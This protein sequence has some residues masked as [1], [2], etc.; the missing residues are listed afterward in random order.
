MAAVNCAR[1]RD[2][3]DK[4]TRGKKRTAEEATLDEVEDCGDETGATEKGKE[5]ANK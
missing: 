4:Q 3:K 5:K 2:Q 1:Q